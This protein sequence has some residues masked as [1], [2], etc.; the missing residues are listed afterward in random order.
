[1][2]MDKAFEQLRI[3]VFDF[4]HGWGSTSCESGFTEFEAKYTTFKELFLASREKPLRDNEKGNES[5]ILSC[6]RC[7]EENEKEKENED[8]VDTFSINKF[9]STNLIGKKK[10]T[11]PT[12]FS[13]KML[14]F[15]HFE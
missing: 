4:C 7:L 12:S 15:Y 13:K 11:F 14:I 2:E 6:E 9:L 5:N 1:M 3:Q 10:Y 8:Y